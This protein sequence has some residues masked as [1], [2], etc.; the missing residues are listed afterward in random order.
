MSTQWKWVIGIVSIIVVFALLACG[1][2]FAWRYLFAGKPSAMI[3]TPPSNYQADEGEEVIVEASAAGRS[4]VRLD[5]WVDG[6]LVDSAS[7][8]SPQDTFSAA[9]TWQATGLGQHTV[10][11]KAYTLAGKESDPAT[12]V[13]IVIPG[14]VAEATPTAT[15]EPSAETPTPTTPPPTATSTSAPEATPT[16]TSPPPTATPTSAPPTA[17]PTP[18]PTDTPTPTSTPGPPVI[19][20]FKA[21]PETIDEGD[22]ST[23]SWGLVS[24]ATSAEIDQGIGGVETPGSRVVSPTTTTTYTMTAVGSGG[25]T[26]ESVTVTVNPAGPTTLFDFVAEAPSAVW[27]NNAGDPINF[28][29]DATCPLGDSHGYACWRDNKILENGNTPARFLITHPKWENGGG[30]TGQYEV[31]EV[32]QA[33]DVFK[34]R[35]GFASG[36]LAGDA[37]WRLGYDDGTYHVLADKTKAY[38]GSLEN[39]NVDLSSLAGQEVDFTLT[40]WANGPSTQDWAIWLNACIE[41]P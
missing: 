26:T 41:R 15:V 13:L 4:I 12:I 33:G 37:K 24:G 25:T 17:T 5:L 23:L 27:Y 3:A 28:H 2:F 30:I 31:N 29:G 14:E 34:A 19:E 36:G 39:F 8:P 32:I 22:S 10:E 18:E 20:F 38:N 7:S 6:G 21:D 35:I 1:I 40:V 9:L 16:A 11:V